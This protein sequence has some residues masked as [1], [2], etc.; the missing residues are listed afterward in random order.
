MRSLLLI[1]LAS[2]GLLATSPTFAEADKAQPK[3]A[4]KSRPATKPTSVWQ[5]PGKSRKKQPA[6]PAAAQPAAS[7]A[8]QPTPSESA[9]PATPAAAEQPAAQPVSDAPGG[10]QTLES[11]PPVAPPGQP[12]QDKFENSPSET[13][14]MA[15]EVAELLR[16]AEGQFAQAQDPASKQ[17]LGEMVASRK[18]EL[19]AVVLLHK[20]QTGRALDVATQCGGQTK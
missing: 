12:G 15:C 19:K 20:R 2:V 8:T 11:Q 9:P 16:V 6:K 14:A 1:I 4:A 7:A 18:R 3:K 13:T 10:A 17:S 5:S